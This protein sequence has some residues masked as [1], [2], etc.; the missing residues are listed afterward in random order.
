MFS[1]GWTPSPHLPL[2]SDHTANLGAVWHRGLLRRLAQVLHVPDIQIT[3]PR[4]GHPQ[5][6]LLG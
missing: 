2:H 5:L 3:A 4:A 6:L 1:G